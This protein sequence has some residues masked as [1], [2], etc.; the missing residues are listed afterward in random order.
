MPK[1]RRCKDR[2]TAAMK[3]GSDIAEEWGG[4]TLLTHLHLLLKICAVTGSP[5]SL[6]AYFSYL[7]VK[8]AYVAVKT[9]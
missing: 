2:H 8:I 7:I 3:G 4:H 1:I 5:A 6:Q 9:S